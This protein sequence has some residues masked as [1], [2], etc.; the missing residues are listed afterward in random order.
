MDALV[1]PLGPDEYGKMP[2]AF[3]ERSQR[4]TEPAEAEEP[5]EE[6]ADAAPVQMRAPLLPRDTYDGVDSDDESSEEEGGPI[7]PLPDDDEESDEDRPQVVG[8]GELDVDMGAEED[9]FLA[10]ARG[11]LGLSDAQWADIVR[12][13]TARGGKRIRGWVL[14]GLLTYCSVRTSDCHC[15]DQVDT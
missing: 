1:A 13:R 15:G 6:G 4:V 10:F 2:A 5:A 7:G 12:D 8:D 3:H 9:E 14:R 11:A